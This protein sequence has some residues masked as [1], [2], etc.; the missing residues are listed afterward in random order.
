MQ[1][2]QTKKLSKLRLALTLLALLVPIATI[3]ALV[4]FSLIHDN[5]SSKLAQA[6]EAM[7]VPDKV[8]AFNIYLDI[9]SKD[10]S[11][12]EAYLALAKLSEN[13]TNYKDAAYFWMRAATL[14]PLDKAPLQKYY[15]ALAITRADE[16]LRGRYSTLSDKNSLNDEIK[17]NVALVFLRAK[18]PAVAD[19]I[20]KTFDKNSQYP[21]LLEACS[22]LFD[23][24]RSVARDALENILKS[25][26]AGVEKNYAH[27]ALA[28]AE[29]ADNKLEAASEQL[30]KMDE[31]HLITLGD[32]YILQGKILLSQNKGAEAVEKFYLAAQ[33]QRYNP[34]ILIECAE[35][36]Y[37]QRN[38][39]ILIGLISQID[40]NNKNMLSLKYYLEALE[41]G[42]KDDWKRAHAA[43]KLSGIFS[44]R[45]SAKLLDVKCAIE[46]GD[47]DAVARAADAIL[48]NEIS[49]QTKLHIANAIT[50]LLKNHQDSKALY[51]A[52]LRI[53]PLNPPANAVKMKHSLSE[54]N[55]KAALTEANN[56]LNA[57]PTE[58]SAYVVGCIAA[59]NM[60]DG[61]TALEL[62]EARLKVDP[63]DAEAMLFA[64]RACVMLSRPEDAKDFYLKSFEA[65]KASTLVG[66]E[67]GLFFINSKMDAEFEKVA[68][69]LEN[70][71]AALK[72]SLALA[73]R[74]ERAKLNNDLEGALKYLKESIVL[75]PEVESLYSQTASVQFAMKDI[76]AA[77]KTLE[78]AVRK[79]SSANL[80]FQLAMLLSNGPK[81]DVEESARI[82]KELAAA[83]PYNKNI[84]VALAQAQFSLGQIED[85]TMT[86]REAVRID[87]K[88][89]N[90]L[91]TLG[92]LL[93]ERMQYAE[94]ITNLERALFAFSNPQTKALLIR[95][96]YAE[97]ESAKSA[98]QKRSALERII[99]L[100]P[101][102]AKA[103]ELLQK[104]N[105]DEKAQKEKKAPADAK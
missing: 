74:S 59:L 50:P 79:T 82:L 10:Q 58:K 98:I 68:A 100:S 1:N 63:A 104:L 61:K 28:I 52:V 47:P 60:K 49:E 57:V 103:K 88:D 29:F 55:F 4:Y 75:T 91:H 90:A 18:T 89:A 32:R 77:R 12:E 2:K 53:S 56:V 67:A 101:E 105:D 7:A 87:P 44:T 33:L 23:K 70:S 35:L 15:E 96:L 95:A 72:K 30:D 26:K 39:R 62:S 66:E 86:A 64:A 81:G 83:V 93:F 17:F 5:T 85:A 19:E 20:S 25:P 3:A 102:D 36:A 45:T 40:S 94:S 54:G 13:K 46:S 37:S 42:T 80:K 51:T 14:N 22:N 31:G 34:I 65:S 69:T 71:D 97:E 43:L 8:K 21:A 6:R 73:L 48:P 41:A 99:S 16:I 84:L 11:C 9:I 92:R 24:N 78:D 38:G 27:L 76:P